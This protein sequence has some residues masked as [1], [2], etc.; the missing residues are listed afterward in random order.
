MNNSR[1]AQFINATLPICAICNKLVD[2][3]EIVTDY[4][5]LNY[6]VIAHCHG[7]KDIATME[8]SFIRENFSKIERG[9][10]FTQKRL[11]EL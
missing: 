8:D 7:D 4:K 5:T 3:L 10:A 2:K 9:L 6:Y 1:E 11:D